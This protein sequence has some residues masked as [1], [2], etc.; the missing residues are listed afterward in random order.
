MRATLPVRIC[1]SRG[2]AAT[3]CAIALT[4]GIIAWL[5]GATGP[6]L[7]PE[8]EGFAFPPV[9]TWLTT[10]WAAM[11]LNMALTAVIAIGTV[12]LNREFN[13]TRGTSVLNVGIFLIMQAAN[14]A[15]IVHLSD[16]TAVALTLLICQFALFA[17]YQSPRSARTAFLIFFMLSL[18]AQTSAA[19]LWYIPVIIIGMI[20]MRT[21]SMRTLTAALLGIVTVPWILLGTGIV[22]LQSIRIPT[23][24][25][26]ISIQAIMSDLPAAAA[27]GLS[28]I[29][30]LTFGIGT[31]LKTYGYNARG[32]AYN[33][34]IDI[35]TFASI[36]LL[37]A[38]YAHS[39]A[40][41]GILN[42][43]AAYQTS[44][45]FTINNRSKSYIAIAGIVALYTAIYLWI[46]LW[47]I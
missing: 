14:P 41:I 2:M 29:I 47:Q 1:H 26:A 15:V 37:L 44:H 22:S 28:I 31:M 16:G 4:G 45:F 5:S 11:L 30:A 12:F 25:P 34:F 24:G 33:G 7:Q 8:T 39:P 18:G 36:A 19:F 6:G 23:F 42:L 40:Y 10:E 13:L 38:D 9:G 17:T 27:I 46:L 3:L 35:L 21:L 20:Q 32:R 43:C